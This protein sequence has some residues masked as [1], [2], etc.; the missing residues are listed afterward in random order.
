LKAKEENQLS[1][2]AK[3]ILYTLRYDFPKG[4]YRQ[5]MV[6]RFESDLANGRRPNTGPDRRNAIKIIAFMNKNKLE[7]AQQFLEYLHKKWKK[8]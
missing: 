5:D 1:D 6:T 8:E 2:R 4:Y 7:T 3:K